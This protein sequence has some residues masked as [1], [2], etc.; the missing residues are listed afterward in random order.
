VV[1]RPTDGRVVGTFADYKALTG[2]DVTTQGVSGAM[3]TGGL[4]TVTVR[5]RPA[6][7]DT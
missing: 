7:P 6:R 5:E 2:Q 3:T 4:V 1:R